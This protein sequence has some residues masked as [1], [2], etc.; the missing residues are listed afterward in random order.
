[1]KVFNIC[2]AEF[3][4]IFSVFVKMI[5]LFLPFFIN[6]VKALIDLQILNH[7]CI[8]ELNQTC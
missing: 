4:Q 8:S 3:C 6:I 2:E 1:M 7:T 5:M